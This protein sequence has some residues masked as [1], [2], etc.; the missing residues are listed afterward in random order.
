MRY[1]ND[2]YAEDVWDVYWYETNLQG[3]VVGIYDQTGKKLIGYTY[4]AWGGQNYHPV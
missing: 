4:D 1:R 3:D 2:T